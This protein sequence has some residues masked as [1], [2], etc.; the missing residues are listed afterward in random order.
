M[1]S[2][3]FSTYQGSTLLVSSMIASTL[4]ATNFTFST[5]QGSTLAFSTINVSSTRTGSAV[6]SVLQGS[7][8]TISTLTGSTLYANVGV[9]STMTGSSLLVS[10][11][12]IS[13]LYSGSI[14]YSTLTGDMMMVLSVVASTMNM[15]RL[16]VSTLSGS[17]MNV[18]TLTGSTLSGFTS[19]AFSTLQGST[20]AV[21]SLVGSTI[22]SGA[23]VFSTMTGSN[24]VSNTV[25][26]TSIT[27]S[28][29]QPT[30]LNA[31]N[32][33]GS[34]MT[35]NS[36]T[37]GLTLVTSTVNAINLN[38]STLIVNTAV[39]SNIN[40]ST[41]TVSLL[42]TNSVSATTYSVRHPVT[43]VTV[44]KTSIPYQNSVVKTSGIRAILDGAPSATQ[45]Y[46]FGP[47]VP[48]RWVVTCNTTNV[49]SYSNDGLVWNGLGTATLGNG[50]IAVWNG[51]MW[52]AV[53]DI[54][55]NTIAYSYN[56]INWIGVGTNIF[57][58]Y[59]LEVAW[60][61]MMW[62][63]VGGGTNS[64]AYSYDGINWTG[65]GNSILS[66]YGHA[67]MWNGTIWVATGIGS[68]TLAY[69]YNGINWF[70][71]GT[72]IFSGAFGVGWNG[73]MWIAMGDG[74]N[75]IAYSYDG[76]TW[77]GLGKG[78]LTLGIGVGWN[79][80]MWVGVGNGDNTIAYS[81]DG[82]IWTGLGASIFTSARR[83]AWNGNMWI[84][85]GSGAN[86]LAYSYNG[87]NW[88]GLGSSLAP[89]AVGMG[90]WFNFAR[91]HR[92]TFPAPMMVATGS[93]TNSLA[94]SSDGI[95]WTASGSSIFSTQGNG[96]ATNGSMWVA[97]GSGTNTLAYSTTDIETPFIYLPFENSIIADVM[98]NS[99][100]SVSGSPA[101]VTG[102]IG[103]KA[104]NF[105]NT[106]G[107]LGTKYLTVPWTGSS[108][109]SISFWFN[110]QTI[111]NTQQNIITSSSGH[112]CFYIKS[113]TNYLSFF[114]PSGGGTSAIDIATSST[115]ILS[116]TWYNVVGV[117]QSNGICS[118]YINN[119]LI[120][121]GSQTGG[122]GTVT[123]TSVYIGSYNG[124]Q[125]FNGYIDDL[126]IYNYAISMNQ[127][128]TWRG[129]GTSVFSSQGNAV[130]WNGT[131]WVAVGGNT[132]HSIAYSYDGI[133]WI[134]LGN[135]I[136]TT[137]NGIAWSGSMWIAVGSG[138]NHT[139]ACSYDG[140][141]WTG[142][143]KGTF[144]V[145]GNGVASNGSL[146]V[147]VGS[148]TNSI[149]Y[150]YNGM[151]WVG[152][153]IISPLF[154]S[155]GNGIAWNGS[156]WVATGTGGNTILYSTD[157]IAWTAAASS[158][159]T[160]AGNG[161][162][163]NGS[164]WVATGSGTNTIGYSVDG[165]TW[166]SST[167][168]GSNT[169]SPNQTGLAS[170][171]WTK[172]GIT[173]TASAS[174]N[175][176]ANYPAYGAFNNYYGM[177][178]VYSWASLNS[179][180]GA[181]GSYGRTIIG[182]SVQGLGTLYGEWIQIQTSMPLVLYSYSYGC[183]GYLNLPQIY[184]IV[185]SN[186]NS[187][188]YP[189]QYVVMNANPLNKNDNYVVSNFSTCS[190]YLLVN[191][192]G[193]QTISGF[194]AATG[195]FVTYPQ[196]TTNTYTYFRIIATSIWATTALFE[197]GEL[198][199]R[200]SNG[201][202]FSTAGSGVASNNG[203][204]GTVTIQ[205]PIIAV[206]SGINSLAYSPDGVQ[207]TG[208]GTTIFST[209]NGVAWNGSKWIACG[210]GTLNTLAYS[211]DG[212]RWTGLGLPVF[213][214]QA[215]GVEW[216]GS[217]WMAVGSGANSIAYSSDGLSWFGST[218]GNDI[219]TTSANDIAWN[220]T[221]W[222]AVGQGT[223]SIAYS[224]DGITWTAISTT[225]FSTKGNGVAWTG[226]L[227]VAVG[228][229]T[230]TISYSSD[231][232]TWSPV[233]SS[234]FTTSGNDI[235]WNGT[236]WVAVG[237]G[238]NTLA[239]SS[240]G[241]SWTG[242]GMNLF[243]VSGNGVCW[244]GTRFVAVGADG[245]IAYS[246]DGLTWYTTTSGIFTQGNGVAG[247]PR[248]GATVSDSQV[249]LSSGTLDVA[250]DS[251]YNTGYNEMSTTIQS[252]S[253]DMLFI[254]KT[255]PGAPTNISGALYPPGN[256]TGV[257]VS[258]DYPTNLGGGVDLYYVSAVD[259]MGVQPTI[260]LSSAT[261]PIYLTG[262]AQGITYRFSV[263]SF[264][265]AGQSTPILSSST[266]MY[267]G[268]PGAPTSA[269]VALTPAGNPIGVLISFIPP[270][271]LGGGVSS[272]IVMAYSGVT[273]VS[274]A[275][276]PSSP[277]TITGLTEG[278]SYTYNVKASNA[279]GTSSAS[280]APTLTYYTKPTAPTLMSV[281]LDSTTTPTGVNVSF[282]AS[283]INGGGI[284]SYTATAYVGVT[285]IASSTGATSPLK[286]TGLTPGT[287][288]TYSVTATNPGVISDASN[289]ATLMY[290]TNPGV[291]Q[292]VTASVT[293]N[294]TTVSWSVPSTTGSSTLASYQ[295]ISTPTGY[296][297]GVLGTST[298][299][300]TP[301]GLANGTSYT[302]TVTVINTGGF[303]N[304][305]T[306]SAVIP[307]T[308]A[309]A[310]TELSST[311]STG[312]IILSWSIYNGGRA[313]S[314]Y[315]IVNTTTSTTISTTSNPYT[316]SGLTNGSSYTF[317]VSATNDGINYGPLETITR[318]V[319]TSGFLY[320]VFYLDPSIKFTAGL[321]GAGGD[322]GGG[323]GGVIVKSE[324]PGSNGVTIQDS[325]PWSP[326]GSTVGPPFN[327]PTIGGSGFGAGGA[328]AHTFRDNN[329]LISYAISGGAG[330]NGF[331]YIYI[332]PSTA[333]TLKNELF[334]QTPGPY[335]DGW[336]Y[337][338][339][340]SSASIKIVVMGGGGGGASGLMNAAPIAGKGGN[341]GM[342][343][344]YDGITVQSGESIWIYCGTG[345]TGGNGVAS[346]TKGGD[347]YVLRASNNEYIAYAYGG[348]GGTTPNLAQIIDG[349]SR[350]GT[351]LTTFGTLGENGSNGGVG[352]GYDEYY[353]LF[354]TT[355]EEAANR[356]FYDNPAIFSTWLPN[357]TGSTTDTSS[358]SN[359]TSNNVPSN[360][361]FKR[362]S[363]EWV[364]RF[365]APF[366]G[367]Y[368]FYTESSD[369]SYVWIGT[370]ATSGFTTSNALV[371]NSGIHDVQE[372]SG[373]ISLTASTYYPIRC[374]FGD[375]NRT[376]SY[377]FSFSGPNIS[378][379]YN[380]TG[381]IVR[382]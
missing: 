164:R 311:G 378:R 33:Y 258:F 189:I 47:S 275:T 52:V 121:G 278:T 160:T 76:V 293:L 178:G 147:A 324:I 50:R 19:L 44:K 339:F 331:V 174:S 145:S 14:V 153:D 255:K 306:S 90:V 245:I 11:A 12:L 79:G 133:T 321:G 48:N 135:S 57:T 291:P 351:V 203:L 208:L 362:Y 360:G 152:L 177:T 284:L 277:L 128:I 222:V 75:S 166:N 66:G 256:V 192:S 269:T 22:T 257:N 73:T 367:S 39:T 3:T 120:G 301:S 248:I 294:I 27:A 141:R 309:G 266:L 363:V 232:I 118:L 1:N 196:Y 98:G 341:G 190:T 292:S 42:T 105:V 262:I 289:T 344:G 100:V 264:N 379:R 263:F 7:T 161:V 270:V 225:I 46:T 238:T 374:Q 179:Y 107:G 16:T 83:I 163:W 132:T 88:F 104:M 240:N 80:V 313:I 40:V 126:R 175:L 299:T 358:I 370:S 260:T 69:S 123:T 112:V 261:S 149:A 380:M 226:S 20:I 315:R 381:Y 375:A 74:I 136:F 172:S 305:A 89:G 87:L 279:A 144:S 122:F 54:G 151:T 271:N 235:C 150:S 319:G 24:V 26:G 336:H 286:I 97:T 38:Y 29:I 359:A 60:N 297:S 86:I 308:L 106:A 228:T 337:Y 259:T 140:L 6:T 125:S 303:S 108:N 239:Y 167:F 72:T 307:Y 320:N 64:I 169:I 94:H 334:Y 201:T 8:V 131:M 34:T 304:S 323:G 56:G 18:S 139:I 338:T 354:L 85:G 143:G 242:F 168:Y 186:D 217:L 219:F 327:R 227:W 199:L 276:G 157:G 267:Q 116:N 130:A 247:N 268:R 15:N 176:N 96:V 288:Y 230:N 355:I 282:T 9:F 53:G 223:N 283:S 146:W 138:T 209:G 213:S 365:L 63:A 91:P 224:A 234:P 197:F 366:T 148:G 265:S 214:T 318:T 340:T 317:T 51:T 348:S 206:G 154:T 310:P 369:A 61:G 322:A 202:N 272:Y 170:N 155:S 114:I 59:G 142:L 28:S 218:S 113:T 335:Y 180:I 345:G 371:N 377:K 281:A 41:A 357:Y 109:F 158:C 280:N 32:L 55:A 326:A 210:T 237:S 37:V 361:A 13:S 67:I 23:V 184:Y 207:W 101:F 25:V 78:T 43:G 290:Q 204:P 221:R 102:P 77:T 65:L 312:E 300:V 127:R 346:G 181:N 82:V 372:R 165:S 30:N 49:L 233:T 70:G 36:M 253:Y 229:G 274:T 342:I 71:L 244:T 162:T 287:T 124:N 328:G 314:A 183:G 58:N 110:A 353:P 368:T 103:S 129:L 216:N 81:Y 350:G 356:Y 364:G 236:R 193:I 376:D 198:F 5:S 117:F 84:A 119:V 296:D 159:F 156:R 4:L 188:F 347:S 295:V 10:T 333:G 99:T 243:S 111:N 182:T 352:G 252:Q 212:I 171:T 215:N 62:V 332:V 316:W 31:T 302:F 343:W 187:T 134:G 329:T 194:I 93:G 115:A 68:D 21:S 251:Y 95:I 185:G 250:S 298:T 200:F 35:T 373:T 285:P 92:I 254:T 2:G 137:G 173:W 330:A 231:G 45:T 17:T 205:H 349:S 249:V 325:T 195:T 241:I 246:Q 191:Q 211:T 220:G 382:W 273:P